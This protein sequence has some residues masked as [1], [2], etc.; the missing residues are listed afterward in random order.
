MDV[1][2][3]LLRYILIL[4]LY[5]F[6][7]R[8]ILLIVRDIKATKTEAPGEMDEPPPTDV[9]YLIIVQ[10]NVPELA[11]GTKIKLGMENYIGR[12]ADNYIQIADDFTSHRHARLS[13]INGQFRLEDLGSKNGTF[14]DGGRIDK[15][16]TLIS[17]GLFQIGGVT[18]R[19]ERWA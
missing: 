14:I 8:I 1:V 9:F 2:L 12:G 11:E 19:L 10:S 4:I 6:I 5:L 7:F 13:L 3:I 15:A 16:V 17:G 18:F